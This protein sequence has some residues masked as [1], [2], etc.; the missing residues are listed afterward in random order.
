[1]KII[2]SDY[3][4]TLRRGNEIDMKDRAAIKKWREAGN[5][6]GVVTGRGAD[7][8]LTASH[9]ELEYDY[10]IVYNGA[11]I[12]NKDNKL[13]KRFLG[14]TEELFEISSVIM[15]GE[16]GWADII[17]TGTR[18]HFTY[19][20]IPDN[21]NGDWYKAEK[22]K[23]IKEFLQIYSLFGDDRTAHMVADELNKRYGG[24]VSALV[25]GSWLNVAP[26]GVTKS[27]GISAYSEY[28]GVDRCDIYTIGDSYNDLDMIKNFNGYSVENGVNDV[29]YAAKGVVGGIWELVERFI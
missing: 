14:I 28:M 11:E 24:S 3:D 21:K 8:L 9:D 25:N 26:P 22:L 2:A 23:E 15:H 4:G 5:L 13:L 18:F 6:F 27:T 20:D 10:L 29:K 1:M 17:V 7:F 19:G 12:Y 16:G